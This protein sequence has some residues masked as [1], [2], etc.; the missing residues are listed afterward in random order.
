MYGYEGRSTYIIRLNE[1][2]AIRSG[3]SAMLREKVSFRCNGMHL[4][5]AQNKRRPGRER[6]YPGGY[7]GRWPPHT[8][9]VDGRGIKQGLQSS[10]KPI[11]VQLFP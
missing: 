9:V 2:T 8:P 1:C 4:L 6:Q 5:P 11:M 3:S 7:P 10:K